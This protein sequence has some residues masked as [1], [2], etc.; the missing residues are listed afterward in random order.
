MPSWSG[1]SILEAKQVWR[2]READRKRPRHKLSQEQRDNVR[3]GLSSLLMRYGR[4]ELAER[5]GLTREGMRLTIKRPPTRRVAVLISF[6]SGVSIDDVLTGV[7]PPVCPT[8]GRH[9]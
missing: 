1:M 7:W 8:C 3:R 9:E 4:R 6:V 2:R 5:M